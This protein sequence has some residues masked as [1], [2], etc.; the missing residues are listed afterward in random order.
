MPTQLPQIQFQFTLELPNLPE[1]IRVEA[2]RRA[3]EAYVMT[4]LKHGIISSGRAG[5]LLG[6]QRLDVIE[7]MGKYGICVFA[8]QTTEEL[9]Q[10]VA[11]SLFLLEQHQK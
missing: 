5:R 3:K 4:L 9:K 10:E 7:L 11:E 1:E 2:E 6:M 8:P